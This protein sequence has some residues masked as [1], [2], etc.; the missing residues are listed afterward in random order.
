L[1]STPFISQYN[2][3]VKIGAPWKS[4]KTRG[5]EGKKMVHRTEISKAIRKDKQCLFN[6][7]FKLD[8]ATNRWTLLGGTGCSQHA[9]HARQLQNTSRKVFKL[10][11]SLQKEIAEYAEATAS[12]FAT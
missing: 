4:T 6:V 2:P 12:S 11:P 10:S 1:H 3:E 7:T 5:S 9:I 8:D